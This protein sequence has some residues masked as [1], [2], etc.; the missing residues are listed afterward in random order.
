MFYYNS[1]I[2]KLEH[3]AGIDEVAVENQF[4]IDGDEFDVSCAAF[5]FPFLWLSRALNPILP[6]WICDLHIVQ[7]A[8]IIEVGC[9]W[10]QEHCSAY[11]GL[12]WFDLFIV[13]EIFLL[14]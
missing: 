3:E 11:I 13:E 8:T 10:T 9:F 5:F 1:I 12:K 4:L 14:N 7:N 6:K 2:K